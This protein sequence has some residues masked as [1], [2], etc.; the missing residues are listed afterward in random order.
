MAAKGVLAALEIEDATGEGE[1]IVLSCGD[2]A[3]LVIERFAFNGVNGDDSYL[4]V[5]LGDALV[6]MTLLSADDTGPA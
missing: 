2:E 1:R 6:C 3:Q 4:E 5:T